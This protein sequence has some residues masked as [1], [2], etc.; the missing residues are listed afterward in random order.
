MSVW[1]WNLDALVLRVEVEPDS[2][3]CSVYSKKEAET[4]WRVRH[5]TL[6]GLTP[7]AQRFWAE[8]NMRRSP[9]VSLGA[10]VRGR[11]FVRVVI[12]SQTILVSVSEV[13]SE[14]SRGREP[15]V[16]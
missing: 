9:L 10:L 4:L 7:I 6:G 11:D 2:I 15:L 1:Y 5:M 16:D 14:K 12:V 8:L 13:P 3:L